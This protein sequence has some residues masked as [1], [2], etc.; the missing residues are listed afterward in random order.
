MDLLGINL[1][2]LMMTSKM[3]SSWSLIEFGHK[4]FLNL[5]KAAADAVEV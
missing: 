2:Q 4:L 3:V 1:T 5:E